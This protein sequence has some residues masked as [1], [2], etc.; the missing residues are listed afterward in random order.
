MK[1]AE[2][3]DSNKDHCRLAGSDYLFCRSVSGN[4][5]FIRTAG[6]YPEMKRFLYSPDSFLEKGRILKDSRS[7]KAAIVEIDQRQYFLKRYNNKGL[8][9]SL[10]YLFRQ[11]RPFNVLKSTLIIR[12]L[13]IP[14]PEVIAALSRRRFGILTASYLLTE[15]IDGNISPE[16]YIRESAAKPDI[17]IKFQSRMCAYLKKMHDYGVRHGDLK[18]NNIYCR[19]D[20][21]GLEFGLYD[22]DGTD[23]F[24]NPLS[25][26]MRVKEYAR[27]ISSWII[28]SNKI[29]VPVDRERIING[30]RKKYIESNGIEMN[31]SMLQQFIE[32]FLNRKRKY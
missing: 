11:S 29:G 7:T 14:C 25:Q 15:S 24:R 16:D 10:K 23:I 27:I 1:K 9:Y 2:K 31:V 20:A 12:K 21:D 6:A 18:L 17:Y 19:K 5:G 13:G 28:I 4:F 8:I 30:F 26:K 32:A 22:F 3:N